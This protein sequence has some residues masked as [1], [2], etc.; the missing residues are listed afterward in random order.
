MNARKV[1]RAAQ[2][3]VGGFFRSIKRA[4]GIVMLQVVGCFF[5]L[6]V[7]AFAPKL[8]QTRACWKSGP[9]HSTFL[10]TAI[11]VAVFSYLGVTSFL[12][13]ARK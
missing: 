4:G 11:F 12:R 8:W 3:G 1:G 13:A 6:P 2:Q 9:D 10:V 7:L 5:F